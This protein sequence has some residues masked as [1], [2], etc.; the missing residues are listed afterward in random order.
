ML[1]SKP[2]AHARGPAT[3]LEVAGPLGKWGVSVKGPGEDGTVFRAEC[4]R[5]GVGECGSECV[6]QRRV[7]LVPMPGGG[8]QLLHVVCFAHAVKRSAGGEG[9]HAFAVD[10]SLVGKDAGLPLRV[11]THPPYFDG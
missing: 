3:R 8:C 10:Q 6:S 9:V 11:L 4:S 1:P 5:L 2:K 7:R